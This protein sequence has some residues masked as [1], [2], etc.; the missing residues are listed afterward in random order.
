[1]RKQLAEALGGRRGMIEGAV[2]TLGFTL[3]YITTRELKLALVI[4]G[5]LAVVLLLV[6]ILQRQS[7]QYVVNAM[8]GIAF[9]AGFALRSGKA[10]DAF[11]P[12]IIWNAIVASLMTLSVLVRW[13]A[14]GLMIGSVTGDLTSWR[15]DP[16]VL[17]LCNR[18]TW[19]LIA[20]SV[21]RISV[22]YPLWLAGE[23]GWLGV[24]KIAL[25]WPLQVA[26]LAVM[27]FIL[28]KGRTPLAQT[29]A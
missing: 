14:V 3:T 5:S 23:V 15:L 27:V 20:P 7:V 6:R 1:M 25:G 28:A 4:G 8:V 26:A 10:E 11:L 19:L 18:L 16:G 17:R 24:T 13:P 29:P 2:P 12:G 21:I 9:A 22:Q